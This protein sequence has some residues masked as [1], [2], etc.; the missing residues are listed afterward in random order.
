MNPSLF[1][2]VIFKLQIFSERLR[3]VDF[4]QS[5]SA[6]GLG[7]SPDRAHGYTS[8]AN[9]HL[10][11]VLD[12]LDVEP[13]D[14]IVDFGCGKGAVLAQMAKYPFRT[15]EGVELSEGLAAIARNNMAKLRLR[16]AV[17]HQAD[18]A[19][20]ADLDRFRFFYFY[21]P[22]PCNVMHAVMGNIQASLEHLP[23]D[24]TIIYRNPKCHDEIIAGGV[25]KKTAEFPTEQDFPLY[26]Y[27]GTSEMA[28]RSRERA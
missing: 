15:V 13:G 18:A 22:F 12:T 26:I 16:Q 25:F 28:D 27:R 7:L 14:S 11:H 1:R 24:V 6:A 17:I 3:G 23:R 19:E 9:R 21:N 4:V 5:M 20:F 10:K 2:R 8:S